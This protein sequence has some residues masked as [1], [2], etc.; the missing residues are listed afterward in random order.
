M[1][2]VPSMSDS[3]DTS[4]MNYFADFPDP[5]MMRARR[6]KLIDI[7]M[8]ALCATLC[9][10]QDFVAITLFGQ[11][12]REWL[13]EFLELP[14]GI[15]SADTFRRVFARMDQAYFSACFVNWVNSIA[16]KVD[17]EI[18]SIDG[19]RI[20]RSFDKAT[21]QA[22]IDMVSAW[23]WHNRMVLGQ[24]KTEDVSNEITAIPE[25]LKM[26]TVKGCLVTIDAAGTQTAIAEQIIEQ[27]GDYLLAV[28]RNQ[29]E[30]HADVTSC[31]DTWIERGWRDEQ[32]RTVE[33]SYHET[34]DFGHGRQEIRR[35]WSM[36]VPDWV[37]KDKRWT[38]LSSISVV[39][40]ERTLD[41]K[42]TSHRRYYISSRPH[43]AKRIGHA[44]RNHW[45]IENSL[46]WVLDMSFREDEA[47]TRT[48]NAPANL[49]VIRHI[50]T[51]LL[52]RETTIKAGA[53]NKM[54]LAAM[55]LKYLQKVLDAA[56]K[57]TD[58]P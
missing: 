15:P 25:L 16:Q 31:L 57:L 39:E 53:K 40:A 51:N 18:I 8:I 9:G 29:P 35:Y 3:T 54:I 22:A 12:R 26:L 7:L 43:D 32:D 21:G 23:S 58:K 44:I 56:S 13:S 27:G 4:L 10:A 17:G 1:F 45:G 6:H 28:K 55:D 49:A 24:V 19:K 20:R 30:L 33:Y 14:G 50:A 34:H 38:K 41:E 42:T 36:P 52:R 11:T 37:N 47:R 2:E 46:H 5:R 48:E